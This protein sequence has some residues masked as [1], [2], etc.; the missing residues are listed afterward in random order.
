MKR[1][2][3]ETADEQ[4]LDW[5]SAF[6]GSLQLSLRNYSAD[7]EIEREH[8]L[9]KEP[10]RI[11]FLVV[12][13]TDGVVIDNAIGRDF[14]KHNIIE[15]KNPRDE[16]NIDTLW[17]VIGYAGIYKS[18]GSKVDEIKAQDI[19]VSI[20]RARKP[21]KLFEQL[22]NEGYVV[23][24]LYPGVYQ[25]SG[26][27]DIPI[28]IVITRELD[29]KEL[30]AMKI[31]TISPAEEDVRSFIEEVRQ[32]ENQGDRKNASAVLKVSAKANKELFEK[33]E[34]DKD[35]GDVFR[36]IFAKDFEKAEQRGID[37]GVAGTVTILRK[38]NHDDKTILEQICAQY[39]LTKAQGKKYLKA[40][41]K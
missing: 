36:E 3:N 18:L 13:K 20:Y 24:R 9:S 41:A 23:S 1:E 33:L 40:E 32:Y 7:I 6:E 12:K 25:V 19:T 21:V 22:N 31:L 34:G 4:R 38:L 8:S 27:I 14:R 11:D 39:N 30:G 2:N 26:I 17:K 5:H 37:K 15:Y 35:M 28:S 10:L 29:D 16:L